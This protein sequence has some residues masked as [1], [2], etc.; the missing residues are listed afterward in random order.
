M[1]LLPSLCSL[2]HTPSLTPWPSPL[3]RGSELSLSL[4]AKPV[5]APVSSKVLRRL[6]GPTFWMV[7]RG[8][9]PTAA[10]CL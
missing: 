9:L 3:H 7:V 4:P 8:D 5:T 10:A 1:S 2:P 6:G